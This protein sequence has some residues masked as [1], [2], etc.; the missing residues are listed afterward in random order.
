MRISQRELFANALVILKWLPWSPGIQSIV[1]MMSLL[2][3]NTIMSLNACE[4]TCLL[5]VNYMKHR[6]GTKIADFG[7]PWLSSLTT[8]TF[9]LEML[10]C[11]EVLVHLCHVSGRL[12]NSKW[13]LSQQKSIIQCYDFV[14]I[15]QRYRNREELYVLVH[16][17]VQEPHTGHYLITLHAS[18]A[19]PLT[20]VDGLSQLTFTRECCG[21]VTEEGMATHLNDAVRRI[22]YTVPLQYQLQSSNRN[23]RTSYMYTIQRK[24]EYQWWQFHW[25]YFVMTQVATRVRSGTSLSNYCW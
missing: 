14:I 16:E 2:S 3:M 12:K 25:F 23:G 17:I 15:S 24:E 4:S 11:I 5:T 22:K 18:C 6:D 1:K 21:K 10:L 7:R 8:D 20:S 9:S 19:I 13:Y